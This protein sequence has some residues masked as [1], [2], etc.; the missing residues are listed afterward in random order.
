M[1]DTILTLINTILVT[2]CKI[3]GF[4]GFEPLTSQNQITALNSMLLLKTRLQINTK[5]K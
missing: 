5:N 3:H 2:A 4:I 1:K